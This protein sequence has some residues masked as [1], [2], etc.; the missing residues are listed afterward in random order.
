[1]TPE[2]QNSFIDRDD[3]S[4]FEDLLQLQDSLSV[5]Q[6][7]NEYGEIEDVD[8]I[9]PDTHTIDENYDASQ[10]SVIPHKQHQSQENN[11]NQSWLRSSKLAPHETDREFEMFNVFLTCGGGRSILYISQICNLSHSVVVKVSKRNNWQVRAADYDRYQLSLKLKEAESA[12]HRQHLQKLENYRE[13]QEVLGHQLSVNAGRIAF[14][15][16]L[17]LS[18]MLDREEQLDIRELPSLLNTASKLAE[19][20]RNLQSSALGVDQLLVAIEE[21]DVGPA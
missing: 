8:T 19:V 20:G 18:Q 11:N 15:A 17:K 7:F 10:S 5:N 21:V 13:Q 9:D 16:N 3:L 2:E 12:R 6:A 4:N 14:L 1:M